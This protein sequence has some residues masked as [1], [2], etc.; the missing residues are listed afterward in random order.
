MHAN[1]ILFNFAL[2]NQKNAQKTL[3]KDGVPLKKEEVDN[4]KFY[5]PRYNSL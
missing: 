3:W 1:K 2:E 5:M 4:Q